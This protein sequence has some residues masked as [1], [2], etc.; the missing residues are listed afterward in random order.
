MKLKEFG[1]RGAHVPRA[2]LDPPLGKIWI[3]SFKQSNGNWQ[4]KQLPNYHLVFEPT[5]PNLTNGNLM[6][7]LLP[8][9]AIQT[10]R[11]KL[12]MQTEPQSYRIHLFDTLSYFFFFT[13]HQRSC[14]KV[15]FSQASVI[16]STG[17]V[18]SYSPGPY[19]L[20]PDPRDHTHLLGPDSLRTTKAGGTHPT[21]MHS[22]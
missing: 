13:T 18:E 15:M 9:I 7:V 12:K 1:P 21:G 20:G 19:P 14:N 16:L 6:I 8:N 4:T 5:F 10:F 2:P 22:C 17:G 3:K 11:L